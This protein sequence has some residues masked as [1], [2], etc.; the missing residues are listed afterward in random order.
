MQFICEGVFDAAVS[1]M[2]NQRGVI[3]RA[4]ENSGSNG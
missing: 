4:A 1:Q 3:G 2:S